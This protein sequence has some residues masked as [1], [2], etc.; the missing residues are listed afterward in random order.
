[1]AIQNIIAMT[2]DDKVGLLLTLLL[3]SIIPL[4]ILDANPG[5][6][7]GG[8]IQLMVIVSAVAWTL[9][10][11]AQKRTRSRLLYAALSYPVATAS[12]NFLALALIPNLLH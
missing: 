6:G 12:S 1:M 9:V 2:V 4:A 5:L 7:V 11:F 8:L 10:R 3:F